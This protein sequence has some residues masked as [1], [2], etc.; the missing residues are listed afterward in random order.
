MDGKTMDT[1]K[2]WRHSQRKWLLG[3]GHNTLKPKQ[4]VFS[5]Q[6]NEFLQL[7]KPRTWF[8]KIIRENDL[9]RITIHGLRHT[10]ASL[11]L[12]SG[13]TIKDIQER[14]GHASVEITSNLYIHITE[15]R[16]DE[17]AIK[18]ANYVGI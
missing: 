12:E 4:L 16:K 2:Q 10:H 18:F 9:K 17:T 15:T 1:L 13:S 6:D 5:N 11:M 3:Y 7:S 14:L 8:K